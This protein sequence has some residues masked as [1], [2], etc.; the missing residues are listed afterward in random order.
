MEIPE[1]VGWTA[2]MTAYARAQ[3]SRRDDALV[4]DPWARAVI[5]R[6]TEA[7][8]GG[9]LPR[10]GPARDDG[11]SELWTSLGTYFVARTPFYDEHVLAGVADGV[12]QVVLLAAGFDGR[13]QRLALPPGTTVFEV[14]SE[15]VL[16][17]KDAALADSPVRDG[18]RRRTVRVDLRDDW[19][20]ALVAAGFDTT[21]PAV[22]LAEGLFMYLDAEQ[23]D[24][25]LATI[26]AL[27]APGSR[28]ATEWFERNPAGEP[29]LVDRADPQ[30]RLAGEMVGSLFRAGP[31]A[32]PREWLATHG[33]EP[34]EVTDV[35]ARAARHGR[36][37]PWMFD[38]AHPDGL[39]VH[40]AAARRPAVS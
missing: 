3:D 20:G 28:V 21:R 31:P 26:G 24:R 7:G 15:P 13:A 40:L 18:V 11:S 5:A 14:D 8:T 12:D 38:P 33:W 36:E 35:G 9:H 4:D 2:L 39:R 25:L 30:E 27:S 37:V 34:V 29:S 1:G 23:S 19:S 32:P 10:L 17:F 22:W 16:D 6:A